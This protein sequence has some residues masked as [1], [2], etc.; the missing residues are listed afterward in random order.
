MII[1][2]KEEFNNLYNWI[3]QSE[4]SMS[5]EFKNKSTF[6]NKNIDNIERDFKGARLDKIITYNY[7]YNYFHFIY[8]HIE[9]SLGEIENLNNIYDLKKYKCDIE[10]EVFIDW[11]FESTNGL[12]RI[13]LFLDELN[14]N[15]YEAI[16]F[17]KFFK[18]YNYLIE[19]SV[20]NDP[21][22]AL[23]FLT[24]GA[25]EPFSKVSQFIVEKKVESDNGIGPIEYETD[26]DVWNPNH[27]Y[28]NLGLDKFIT[29]SEPV[30]LQ[31]SFLY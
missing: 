10:T 17:F 19:D 18:Y 9:Y 11:F 23:E 16:K 29:N 22:I 12:K 1:K 25:Y 5:F 3:K 28:L 31:A 13:I 15:E 14:K 26:Y 24:D 21:E 8:K 4:T 20:E 27:N 6:F 2:S 30:Y 7:V